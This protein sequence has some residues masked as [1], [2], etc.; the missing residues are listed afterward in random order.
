MAITV[1][2][3]SRHVVFRFTLRE[4]HTTAHTRL[5]FVLPP[6]RAYGPVV[7]IVPLKSNDQRLARYQIPSLS[8]LGFFNTS[9][10]A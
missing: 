1:A 5:L 3:D 6:G 8:C 4:L 2:G 9:G 7:R 10:A